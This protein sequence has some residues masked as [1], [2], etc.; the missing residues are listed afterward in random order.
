[1]ISPAR[2]VDFVLDPRMP[3]SV[4]FTRLKGVRGAKPAI[5]PFSD[6]STVMVALTFDI[7]YDFG[8][9]ATEA[10]Y[11]S[12]APFL[13][14][15]P[16]WGKELEAV[17]TL[18]VQGDMVEKLAG[19][20][21]NLQDEHEIGLH[22]YAHEL[23]GKEKWFLPHR[24]VPKHKRRDLLEL[25]LKCFSDN[26]LTTP[27]SFRAPDLVADKDTL[28][29]LEESGFA[30]DSSAPSYYGVPPLPTR[31]LGQG[32]RLLSIPITVNPAPRYET[33]YGIPFAAYEI[34]NMARLVAGD[35]AHFLDYVRQ[36][37]S[38]Q[39]GAG[40]KP[41][42]VFLAHPWEFMEWPGNRRPAYCS[43][44]NYQ[45][46]KQKL[47]LLEERYSLKYVGVKELSREVSA[48]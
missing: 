47:S 5:I 43:G 12:A 21:H 3:Q 22:G 24:A 29:L 38:F 46:L 35:D 10:A 18:F 39:A 34:L 8:S 11:A 48:E 23:W 37:L 6:D 45:L 36:V 28:Q 4:L 9:S 44:N 1:M 30:V 2:L 27:S 32:S 14:R 25:S 20:L 13:E 41:H 19:Y 40:V 33:R 26:D 42:L 7:E 16:A 15:L 17:L 31:P